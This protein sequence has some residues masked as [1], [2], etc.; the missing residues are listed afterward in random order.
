[1]NQATSLLQ[2]GDYNADKGR[3]IDIMGM[4]RGELREVTAQTFHCLV[5]Q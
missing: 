3:V 1:M 2:I 5:S 4:Y